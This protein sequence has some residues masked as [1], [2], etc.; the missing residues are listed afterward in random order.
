M[1]S[2]RKSRRPV[3]NKAG[4]GEVNMAVSQMDKVT[5]S[6]TRRTPRTADAAEE[7]HNEVASMRD[8]VTQLETVVSGHRDHSTTSP[9]GTAACGGW[10][11]PSARGQKARH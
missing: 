10:Q 9:A 2:L 6:P 5:R 11:A 3:K 4:I 8:V 7:L 1:K